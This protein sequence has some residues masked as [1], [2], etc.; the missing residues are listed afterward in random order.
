MM[1]ISPL[2]L[3]TDLLL[4]VLL[5]LIAFAAWRAR[6]SEPMRDAWRRVGESWIGMVSLTILLCFLLVGVLDSLHYR[7]RLAPAAGSAPDTAGPLSTEVRSALD[8]LAAPLRQR[9]EKT[10]SAPLAIHLYSRQTVELPDGT[11]TRDFP[12]LKYAGA[13][14]KYPDAD[15][16]GDVSGRAGM[17]LAAGAFTWTALAALLVLGVAA[18]FAMGPEAERFKILGT[19]F[20]NLIKM[21]VVP[22]IFLALVSGITSMAGSANF[23]RVGLKGVIAYGS[24]AL[25]AVIIGLAAVLAF[26]KGRFPQKAKVGILVAAVVAVA[27]LKTFDAKFWGVVVMGVSVIILGFLPWLDRSPVKS[28]RYRPDWHMYVYAVFVAF[29]LVLGYLGVQPP[30][31]TGEQIGRAHV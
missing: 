9:A 11:Q 15:Y 2:V 3:W 25:F 6:S 14:L 23:K 5:A 19:I 28:I 26:L 1:A 18:G 7:E 10:Y 29:F 17:G 30:S 13:T 8:A 31:P 21:V 20:I 4:F 16:A 22:L 24:T 12:R 27:L